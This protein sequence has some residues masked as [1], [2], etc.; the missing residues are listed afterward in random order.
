MRKAH[1]PLKVLEYLGYG[2]FRTHGRKGKLG[3]PIGEGRGKEFWNFFGNL[4][5]KSAKPGE[6]EHPSTSLF[7][8]FSPYSRWEMGN[9]SSPR[10]FFPV[11]ITV[12][13]KYFRMGLEVTFLG[14]VPFFPPSPG[15]LEFS[16]SAPKFH[17]LQGWTSLHRS[18]WPK[19]WKTPNGRP[20]HAAAVQPFHGKSWKSWKSWKIPFPTTP[21][22]GEDTWIHSQPPLRAGGAR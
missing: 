16:H 12:F 13:P 6:P 14:H 2:S 15:N 22:G 7:Q 19:S 5:P 21:S 20:L 3:V 18:R 17:H 4:S 11:F 10:P 8:G 1:F 9:C